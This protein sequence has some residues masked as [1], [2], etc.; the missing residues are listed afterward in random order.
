MKTIIKVYLQ[1]A[2]SVNTMCGYGEGITLE[3]AIQN[4][5]T[6]AKRRDPNAFYDGR[7]VVFSESVHC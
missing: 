5:L 7:Q 3:L 2:R 6:L 4:A 1:N